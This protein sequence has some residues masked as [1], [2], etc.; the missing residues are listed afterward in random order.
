LAS[1]R[2]ERWQSESFGEGLEHWVKAWLPGG[3]FL[4]LVTVC[5][6]AV[7][8]GSDFFLPSALQSYISFEFTLSFPFRRQKGP[9]RT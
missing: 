2:A 6:D 1:E 8:F 9:S 3:G 4:C 5:R 7:L